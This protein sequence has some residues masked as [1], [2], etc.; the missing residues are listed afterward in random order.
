MIANRVVR[1]IALSFFYAATT[2]L[3]LATFLTWRGIYAGETNLVS[4]VE[5]TAA[6]PYVF[7][8]LLPSIVR[9]STVG[10]ERLGGTAWATVGEIGSFVLRRTHAPAYAFRHA[11]LYGVYAIEA[12]L[13]LIGFALLLRALIRSVYPRYPRWIADLAPLMALAT[14]PVVFF[15]YVS[16]MYDPMTLLVF[17][18]GLYLI[19]ERALAAYLIFF[20]LAVL[21][22]ETA[23]LLLPVLLVR[24]MLRD[25][26][27]V[28]QLAVVLYHV[29]ILFGFRAILAAAFRANPGSVVIFQGPVN[30]ELLRRPA[31][32]VRTLVPLAPLA[33][34]VFYRWPGKPIFLRRALFALGVPLLLSCLLFAAL[35][36]M[37][38]YYSLWPLAFLLV[39]HSVAHAFGWDASLP[40][41]QGP[42]IP[43]GSGPESPAEPAAG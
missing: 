7:R 40:A 9:F 37:R 16:I 21:A 30:L 41:G 35:G 5:G 13:C 17:A 14:L 19:V 43:G 23:I 18:L 32:Y 33:I 26:P 15:R 11:H 39:T 1:V 6:K 8:M 42:A 29:A 12:F 3:V 25:L 4:M 24:G 34:L 31:L 28:R 22:K 20:P 38:N 27:R 2:A 36:E 10:V